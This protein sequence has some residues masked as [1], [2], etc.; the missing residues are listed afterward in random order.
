MILFAMCWLFHIL[1]STAMF[2]SRCFLS[3]PQI[4]KPLIS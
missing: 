2:L 1:K 4:G 3:K